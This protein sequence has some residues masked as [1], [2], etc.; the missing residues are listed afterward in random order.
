M[1]FGSACQILPGSVCDHRNLSPSQ[2]AAI[3][4]IVVEVGLS[5]ATLQTNNRLISQLAGPKA[6]N[7]GGPTSVVYHSQVSRQ[8]AGPRG[9][10][11]HDDA[12]VEFFDHLTL[13]IENCISPSSFSSEL[14]PILSVG[15]CKHDERNIH[16]NSHPIGLS[17][18]SSEY[19]MSEQLNGI[20]ALM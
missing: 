4:S 14:I 11:H 7:W 13:R 15:L 12:K 10:Y 17:I 8:S 19:P 2:A 3:I 16:K 20:D 5:G 1:E 6:K 9:H 18:S